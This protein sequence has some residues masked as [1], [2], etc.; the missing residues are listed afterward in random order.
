MRKISLVALFAALSMGL[1]AE[2]LWIDTT[3]VSWAE[4]GIQIGATAF[5]NA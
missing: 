2:D 1:F 3:H 5:A 4:G